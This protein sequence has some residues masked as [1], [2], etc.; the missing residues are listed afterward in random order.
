MANQ[1]DATIAR[2]RLF[3][4]EIEARDVQ[5]QALQR[6]FRDQLERV[7]TFALYREPSLDQTL[8][9]MADVEQRAEAAD[10]LARRLGH[11]RAR[12]RAEVESLQLTKDVEGAKS[13][14]AL[15][16]ARKAEREAQLA[17]EAEEADQAVAESLE[18]LEGDIRRLQALIHEASERAA[19]R[20]VGQKR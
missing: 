7:I 11:L 14:L 1:L 15:L 9:M 18:E 4:A 20:V 19:Q 10:E 5:V 2:L 8:T 13:E 3:L 6:Q 16:E 12:V 17:V